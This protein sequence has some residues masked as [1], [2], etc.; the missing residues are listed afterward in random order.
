MIK[1]NL[2]FFTVIIP[3]FN[4]IEYLK[5]AINSVRFQ[6]FKSWNLHI[7]DNSS[8]DGT[9]DYLK[10]LSHEDKRIKFSII[11][12]N[13]IIAKSRNY[14][15]RRANTKA[16]SFL[17]DDDIW[18]DNKLEDDFKILKE[19]QGLTYSRCYSFNEKN[20]I[21]KSLPSRNIPIKNPIYDLLHYGNIFTT[22]SI[23]FSLNLITKKIL[24]NE[25][26]EFRTWEDYDLWLRLI[27]DGKLR[28]FYTNK[29]SVKYRISNY[30][31]SSPK[32]DIKNAQSISKFHKKYYEIHK[33]KIIDGLPLWA[34]YSNMNSYILIGKSKY[35]ILSFV[36]AAW[37]SL[38]TFDFFFFF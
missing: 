37:L 19:V 23:S 7:V 35:S 32:Q 5:E 13:G 12:N 18:L 21:L 14:A 28:V 36:K 34:H 25:S 1:E 11:K 24:F 30:Q 16:V 27:M 4:R 10:K 15:L 17:D 33:L 3:T 38:L 6:R 2:P 29:F 22:S 8:E 20:N 31:Y 26:A 9:A